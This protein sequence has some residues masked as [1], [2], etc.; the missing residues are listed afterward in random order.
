M[1]G[2]YVFIKHRPEFVD[3]LLFESGNKYR[4]TVIL[5]HPALFEI[6]QRHRVGFF[7]GMM[8]YW[9][10]SIDLIKNRNH[11]FVD[12]SQFF[13]RFIYR[14]DLVLKVW[15]RYVHHMD[16]DICLAHL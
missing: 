9:V 3:V 7:A 12:G 16:Q 14:S 11:L 8:M 2:L 13:Q 5:R 4:R 1:Y 6:F 10:I 15:M